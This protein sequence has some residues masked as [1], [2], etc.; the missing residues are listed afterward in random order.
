MLG[1]KK[2]HKV[3][4]VDFGLLSLAGWQLRLCCAQE[5]LLPVGLLQQATRG[6]IL[7]LLKEFET[8][9]TPW[10]LGLASL[11]AVQ[12]NLQLLSRFVNLYDTQLAHRDRDNTLR[13]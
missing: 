4:A 12:K 7:R 8:R 5:R 11:V 1:P 9:F 13:L 2:T 6:D 3:E 10:P